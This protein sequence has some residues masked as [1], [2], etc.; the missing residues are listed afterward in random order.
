MSVRDVLHFS[1]F[2]AVTEDVHSLLR[3]M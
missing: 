1:I 3:L 2:Y